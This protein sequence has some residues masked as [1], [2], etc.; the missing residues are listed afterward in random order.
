MRR[1]RDIAPGS[2][3]TEQRIRT[4]P[5]APA[6]GPLA[7]TILVVGALLAWDAFG[8]VTA[9]SRIAPDVRRALDAGAPM[10]DVRV[11]VGFKLEA[12]HMRYFQ[13]QG[14]V[15]DVDSRGVAIRD[16]PAARLRA[17]ARQYWISSISL[18]GT[19]RRP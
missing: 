10:L 19:G 8:Y 14:Q 9:P 15:V 18:A 13:E 11:T 6:A 1:E 17:M 7:V 16:V 2:V 12:F 4:L 5:R 3:V